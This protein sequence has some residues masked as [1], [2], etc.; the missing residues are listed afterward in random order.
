MKNLGKK[1][2]FWLLG[3]AVFAA[4]FDVAYWLIAG[5]SYKFT[6]FKGVMLPVIVYFG[7]SVLGWILKRSRKKKKKR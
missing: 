4:V 1:F 7:V 2:L 3:I 5:D 6:F